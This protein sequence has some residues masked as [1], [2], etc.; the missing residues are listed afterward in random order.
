VTAAAHRQNTFNPAKCLSCSSRSFRGRTLIPPAS[1]AVQ[2][3]AQEEKQVFSVPADDSQP[4][5]ALSGV[6]PCACDHTPHVWTPVTTS[7]SLQ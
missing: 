2:E 5:C 4:L 7:S 1:A 6:R 3:A